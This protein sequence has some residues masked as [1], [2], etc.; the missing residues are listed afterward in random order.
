M[1]ELRKTE[2]VEWTTTPKRLRELSALMDR[3]VSLCHLGDEIPEIRL[4]TAE[5]ELRII[6]DVEA[7]K[8]DF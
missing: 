2:V 7:P 3:K 8:E 1:A 5:F 6:F 4:R